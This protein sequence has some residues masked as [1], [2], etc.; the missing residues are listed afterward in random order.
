MSDEKDPDAEGVNE[1]NNVLAF[2][3]PFEK[4]AD[5]REH[6]N[7]IIKPDPD[8]IRCKCRSVWVD[9]RT[10]TLECRRCGRVIEPFDWIMT[11]TEFERKEYW[12]LVELRD[13]IARRRESLEKL[14]KAEINTRGRVRTAQFKLND[15]EA[16]VW[17]LEQRE[18][19]LVE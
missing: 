18:K 4:N 3:K 19:G 1:L 17:K 13:E 8:L 7:L 15:L 11:R 10:R 16:Q 5:I 6:L 9:Q 2:T 12:E 14:K